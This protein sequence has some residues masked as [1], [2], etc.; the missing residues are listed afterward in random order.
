M[1]RS[2]VVAALGKDLHC[3]AH[4]QFRWF[5]GAIPA[6]AAFRIM[7]SMCTMHIFLSV[8]ALKY[9]TGSDGAALSWNKE[10]SRPGQAAWGLNHSRLLGW[11]AWLACRTGQLGLSVAEGGTG[12]RVGQ[13]AQLSCVVQ[14]RRKHYDAF[15]SVIFIVFFS[16]FLACAHRRA[17]RGKSVV[18]FTCSG[19]SQLD[20]WALL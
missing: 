4:N 1:A 17:H 11:V 15:G 9:H 12:E 10:H 7:W 16:F 8:F 3:A 20:F 14:F 5:L 13:L 19:L 18:L 6:T 2:I